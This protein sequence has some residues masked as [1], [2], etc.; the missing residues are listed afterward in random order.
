MKNYLLKKI[1][2]LGPIG[3]LPAPGTCATLATIPFVFLLSFLFPNQYIY[4]LITFFIFLF[5]LFAVSRVHYLFAQTDPREIV[6]DELVGC[7][8]TFWGVQLN[9]T[10]VITGFILFRFFDILKV[11]GIKRFEQMHGAWGIMLD[12]VVAAFV[13]NLILR[14]VGTFLSY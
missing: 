6:I 13:C 2:T 5:S 3:Y 4:L 8:I 11:G 9:T 12:D 7:L 10:M 14:L 1:A